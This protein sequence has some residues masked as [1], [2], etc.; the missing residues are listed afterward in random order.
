MHICNLGSGS[1]VADGQCIGKT[2][3]DQSEP[4]GSVKQ[5]LTV[6]KSETIIKAEDI[7]PLSSG[8]NRGNALIGKY[9]NQYLHNTCCLYAHITDHELN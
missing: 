1:Q 4:D 5:K 9:N 3:I 2:N 8:S 7:Y 6:E